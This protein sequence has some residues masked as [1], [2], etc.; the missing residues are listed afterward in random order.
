M[1]MPLS[2]LPRMAPSIFCWR[3]SSCRESTASSWRGG[4]KEHMRRVG[5]DIGGTFT[6]FAVWD[7]APTGYAAVEAFKVPSTPPD[8]ARGV[9]DGIE[10]LIERGRIVLDAPV[11]IVHGTTV[12]T[13]AVI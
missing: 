10:A 5:I 2:R 6:D 1:A 7:G 9:K 13:N 4:R 8:F 12:S 3:T 11:L